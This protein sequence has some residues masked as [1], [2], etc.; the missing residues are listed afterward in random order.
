MLSR[1][2]NNL[3]FGYASNM[4]NPVW[5]HAKALCLGVAAAVRDVWC[6]P[7]CA[8]G[9]KWTIQKHPLGSLGS[10]WMP[11]RRLDLDVEN[12]QTLHEMKIWDLISLPSASPDRTRV[13]RRW[14]VK[15]DQDLHQLL[16]QSKWGR[17]KSS[18]GWLNI[19]EEVDD[20]YNWVNHWISLNIIYHW[21]GDWS[22]SSLAKTTKNMW[23]HGYRGAH[24]CS[25]T[26]QRSCNL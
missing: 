9:G 5:L 21:S 11:A 10:E 20:L 23:V 26:H 4:S 2:L 22:G 3:A 14:P 19:I 12:Q 25:N 17:W 15:N 18:I 13:R 1:C 7:R 6:G 16:M 24:F 8:E